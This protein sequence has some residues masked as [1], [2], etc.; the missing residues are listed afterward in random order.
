MEKQRIDLLVSALCDWARQ[1]NESLNAT[2]ARVMVLSD[3][4]C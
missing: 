1:R 2:D 4:D 3:I